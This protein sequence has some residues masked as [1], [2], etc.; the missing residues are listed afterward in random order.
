M[1]K[2]S[3]LGHWDE[4]E[5]SDKSVRLLQFDISM[6][7]RPENYGHL[8]NFQEISYLMEEFSMLRQ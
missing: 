4:I 1:L 7:L 3:K 8:R 2:S 6:T 5:N